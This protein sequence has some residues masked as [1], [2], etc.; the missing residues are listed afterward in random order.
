[1]ARSGVGEAVARGAAAERGR[2]LGML[3]ATWSFN[4]PGKGRPFSSTRTA[5]GFCLVAECGGPL[6]PDLWEASHRN[7]RS[8]LGLYS[9]P[10]DETVGAAGTVRSTK[11]W[12][13]IRALAPQPARSPRQRCYSRPPIAWHRVAP[14]RHSEGDCRYS[15]PN[16]EAVESSSWFQSPQH[17][18]DY[19]PKYC[20]NANQRN[21]LLP[22]TRI[23][24][25]NHL[26]RR[27]THHK[28]KNPAQQ[29]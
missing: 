11:T 20:I 22:R 24:I 21:N 12:S 4:M 19:K 14:Q 27:H 16:E 13:P 1:M 6:D 3:M 2:Q 25:R 29:T 26:A 8:V 17:Y 9:P 5:R 7:R 15:R 18:P 10:E 23:R 28:Q